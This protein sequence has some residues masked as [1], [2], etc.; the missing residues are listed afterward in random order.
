[1][2]PEARLGGDDCNRLIISCKNGEG[3]G[4]KGFRGCRCSPTIG[5]LHVVPHYG[6]LGF[7]QQGAAFAFIEIDYSPFVLALEM[8]GIWKIPKTAS[9]SLNGFAQYVYL[10]V[11]ACNPNRPLK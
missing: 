1:M 3:L 11:Y 6:A 10:R 5:S 7:G 4:S 8:L 2:K 9:H